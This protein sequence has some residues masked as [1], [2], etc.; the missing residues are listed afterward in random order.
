MSQS[1]STRRQ[2]M[3]EMIA[4]WQQS[5]RSQTSFCKQQGISFYT[6]YYWYR[7]YKRSHDTADDAHT[8]G[9]VQLRVEGEPVAATLVEVSLP[10]GAKVLFHT[11]VS[12][13]YLKAIIS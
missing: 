8:P 10:G 7:K 3:F 11:P 13:D 9:F 4:R 12:A 6:F 5:G 2:Q 1:N